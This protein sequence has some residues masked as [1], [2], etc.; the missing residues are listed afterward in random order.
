MNAPGAKPVEPLLP[1]PEDFSLVLGGP[2]YQLWLRTRLSGDALQ[3]LHRRIIALAALAWVPLLL[4]SIAEGHAWGDSVDLP[5]FHD[6]EVHLRFLLSLPLL[7]AAELIVH[8]RMRPAVVQF[9]ERGL[10]PDT[11]RA[12]FD[13][14]IASAMR[15]RN[16]ITAEILLIAIVYVVGVGFIW[17]TQVAVHVTSWYGVPADG[18]LQ[19]SLAGWWLGCVSLPLYQFLLLRW[20]F[21]LFIWARFLWQVASIKL[22]ILPTH[23]DGC[24][25]MSFLELVSYA[26]APFLLA[27][28]VALAGMAANH[29]FY[30]GAKLV[31]LKLEL[32]GLVAVLVFIILGPLLVFSPQL[33]AAKRRALLEYGALAQRQVR[34]LD[35][36]WLHGGTPA[37]EPL[38]ANVSS[39]F[40]AAKNMRPAPFGMR[41]V[42]ELAVVTLLPVFPLAL[43]RMPLEEFLGRVLKIIF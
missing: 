43:T 25:G 2:L 20:Y 36:K 33:V 28:G 13:A 27:Q 32:V 19:P 42:L 5:F 31:D 15:L 17:R 24:G 39:S 34:E 30:A 26:L 37:A 21:R 41:T 38:D 10:I 11:A 35:D 16:S 1:K 8:L 14:A 4:L 40:Q 29:I 7:V 18:G 9:L 6:I 3:R 12:Q 23:P 22:R